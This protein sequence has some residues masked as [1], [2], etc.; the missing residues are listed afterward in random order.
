MRVVGPTGEIVAHH[1]PAADELFKPEIDRGRLRNLLLDSLQP[2]TVR[3]AHALDGVSGP[4]HGP[5]TL[6]FADGTTEETDLVIGADGAF[7]RVRPAVSPAVPSYT[8]VSFL[9]AWFDDVENRH[10]DV[11]QLVGRGSAHAADGAR[12]L[13][14]CGGCRLG[15]S[16]C[17]GNCARRFRCRPCCAWCATSRRC[18]SSGGARLVTGRRY[19]AAD[20]WRAAA[21]THGTG[22]GFSAF[23]RAE[24][25]CRQDLVRYPDH[26]VAGDLVSDPG[27]V[28]QQ[29]AHAPP[30][31]FTLS[32]LNSRSRIAN[33]VTMAKASLISHRSTSSFDQPIFFS[34]FCTAPMG[35]IVNNSG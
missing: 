28:R 22:H 17:F 23:C 29:C 27:E 21:F 10:A 25:F 9:E 15:G 18:A 12:G 4:A 7:S 20:R 6:H 11:S 32:W 13:W 8:G 33:M 26:H 31:T 35:A 30:C 5:R 34:N 2:E 16:S 3:W 1:I 14:Y 24:R 19:V